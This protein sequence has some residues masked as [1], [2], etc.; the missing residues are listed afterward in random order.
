MGDLRGLPSV[1][2]LLAAG[3]PI[4]D[5]HGRAAVTDAQLL[6]SVLAHMLGRRPA[7]T[8]SFY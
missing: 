6:N 8:R 5:R 7:K 3:G 2:R 1:D 4:L